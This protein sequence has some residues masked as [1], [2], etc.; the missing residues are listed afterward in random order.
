MTE[1]ADEDDDFGSSLNGPALSMRLP[2]PNAEKANLQHGRPLEGLLM[3]KNRRLQDGMT[4]LRVAQEELT[5][6]LQNTR[7]ELEEITAKYEEQKSLNE[8]LE[9]DLMRVNSSTPGPSG[10][11]GNSTPRGGATSS[12]LLAPTD[13]SDPLAALNIGRKSMVS[14][15]HFLRC[16][17]Q[18]AHTFIIGLVSGTTSAIIGRDF[19]PTHHYQPARPLQAEKRRAGRAIT[20]TIRDCIGA[21][22]RDKDAAG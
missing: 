17:W 14:L 2:N 21:E 4:R 3:S 9:N 19:D 10:T 20:S 12:S 18:Y 11:A 15:K 22:E 8:K 13:A 7:S 1:F 16:A 5:G 6:S